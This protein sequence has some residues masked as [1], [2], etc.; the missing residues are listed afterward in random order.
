MATGDDHQFV[1]DKICVEKIYVTRI[2]T[3]IP[4][5]F[6]SPYHL[7]YEKHVHVTRENEVSQRRSHVQT[8]FT[9]QIKNIIYILKE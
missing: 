4:F 5:A 6:I 1:R 2:P 8:F 9:S 3:M 7:Y